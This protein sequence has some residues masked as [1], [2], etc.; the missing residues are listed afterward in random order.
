[1]IPILVHGPTIMIRLE[2]SN[3]RRLLEELREILGKRP[4]TEEELGK[5]QKNQTLKLPG[6]WETNDRVGTSISEIVR[7]PAL[8]A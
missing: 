1:M 4:V 5:A 3:V 7:N 8:S 2:T 6:T